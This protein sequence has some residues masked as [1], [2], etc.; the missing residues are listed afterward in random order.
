MKNKKRLYDVLLSS[1]WTQI[2]SFG[3]LNQLGYEESWEKNGTKTDLFSVAYVNGRYINGMTVQGV[4]YPCD[5]FLERYVVHTWND[6]SFRVPE[7]IEPYLRAKYGDWKR[8]HVRGY[9]WHV[10]PF[11]TD[12]GRK[13]CSKTEMPS[14]T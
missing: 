5:S 1:G 2:N 4:T 7:P 14:K 13:F 6:I 10:E 3:K 8:N 11:K 9:Q 12:N